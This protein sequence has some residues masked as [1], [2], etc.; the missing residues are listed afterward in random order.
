LEFVNTFL[1]KTIRKKVDF[2]TLKLFSFPESFSLRPPPGMYFLCLA[3]FSKKT[4]PRADSPGDKAA[5][6]QAFPYTVWRRTAFRTWSAIRV[7]ATIF[8]AS[9]GRKGSTHRERAAPLLRRASPDH[10]RTRGRRSSFS[11]SGSSHSWGMFFPFC[12]PPGFL[13]HSFP[14]FR[15]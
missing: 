11:R 10:F 4:H 9:P 7:A 15:I 13:H 8:A 1:F 12:F 2:S 14:V 6:P 3:L 5:L